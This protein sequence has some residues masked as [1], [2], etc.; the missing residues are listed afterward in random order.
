MNYALGGQ[1]TMFWLWRQHRADREMPHG[2]FI[3]AWGKPAA[4]YD[5][6]VQLGTDISRMSDFMMNNPVK[7]AKLAMVYSHE[8]DAGFRIE[9]YANG[10]KYYIDW[11]YRF[12]R[13]V[14]DAFIHRDVINEKTDIQQYKVLLLPLMPYIA[15]NM[16]DDLMNW[17]ESGGILLLGPMSGY[18]TEEWT[19]FTDYAT[20]PWESWM[21][22]EVESKIPVGT[23]IRKAEIPLMLEFIP[24][25]NID[26]SQA[27]LWSESLSTKKGKVLAKYTVGMHKDKPAI[28]ESDVGKGKVVFLGCDPGYSAYQRLVSHYCKLAG[29]E[30]LASGDSDVLIVPR[31]GDAGEAFFIINLA[32]EFKS[33]QLNKSVGRDLFNEKNVNNSDIKLSPYQIMLLEIKN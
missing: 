29:I 11:T 1:G 12:Y 13:P 15:D 14:S 6:L 24:V 7:K 33:I 19:S 30:V 20:G 2:S 26:D 16:R 3:N 9:E 4:N 18:R 32:N 22:I 23:E 28:I 10:L 21:D 27:G 31:V 17:V 25:L 5:E 8:N